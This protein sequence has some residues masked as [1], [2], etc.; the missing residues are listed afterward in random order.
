[1]YLVKLLVKVHN[2]FY[3]RE[4]QR[5][6][7][8][9]GNIKVLEKGLMNN[10]TYN[11]NYTEFL[12]RALCMWGNTKFGKAHNEKLT[13]NDD[14][15]KFAELSAA[16]NAVKTCLQRKNVNYKVVALKIANPGKKSMCKSEQY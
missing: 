4:M 15:C 11:Y 14:F 1:M 8:M 13:E 16:K 3:Q 7:C 12:W 10:C 6:L 2:E 9:W 5:S